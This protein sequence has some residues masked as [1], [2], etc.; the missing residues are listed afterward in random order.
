VYVEWE[1][2][3]IAELDSPFWRRE[4]AHAPA[5]KEG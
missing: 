2:G 1:G 3:W 4:K 5:K